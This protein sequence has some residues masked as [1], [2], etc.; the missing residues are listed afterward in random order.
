[1]LTI[2]KVFNEYLMLF[3]NSIQCESICSPQQF[4]EN[5]WSTFKWYLY[6]FK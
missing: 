2:L 4:I 1:M 5:N 6:L 3:R